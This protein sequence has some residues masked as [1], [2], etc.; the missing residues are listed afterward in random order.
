MLCLNNVHIQAA[1]PSTPKALLKQFEKFVQEVE[2]SHPDYNLEDW[3]RANE[4]YKS[5]VKIYYPTFKDQ[6]SPE[7]IEKFNYLQGKYI[8]FLAKSKF[9]QIRILAKEWLKYAMESSEGFLDALF[10]K[11]L[12]ENVE[13]QKEINKNIEL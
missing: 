4:K 6:L 8:G 13:E 5:F 3:N 1:K 2:K 12:Q 10:G 7:Q 11:D 9:K